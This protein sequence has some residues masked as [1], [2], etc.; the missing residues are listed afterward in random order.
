MKEERIIG[1][2]VKCLMMD[3][4]IQKEDFLN[5][6]GY[7]NKDYERLIAGRLYVSIEEANEMASFFGISIGEFMGEKSLSYYEEHGCF[8]VYPTPCSE[9][10][11]NVVLDLMDFMLDIEE[12]K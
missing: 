5:H 3:Q 7:A 10:S 2:N 6:F 11:V 8:H 1:Y 12:C 9:K 4:G